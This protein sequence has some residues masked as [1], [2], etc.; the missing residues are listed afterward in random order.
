[1]SKKIFGSLM[2]FGVLLLLCIIIWC[3]E[4]RKNKSRS[5]AKQM[6]RPVGNGDTSI[7]GG[8]IRKENLVKHK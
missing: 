8:P 2:Y 3:R 5:D 1:M 7:F 6:A 4:D